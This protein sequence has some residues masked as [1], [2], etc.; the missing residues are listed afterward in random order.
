MIRTFSVT[1]AWSDGH[2]DIIKFIYA[3]GHA[4]EIS[5]DEFKSQMNS[6]IGTSIS[7]WTT[8]QKNLVDDPITDNAYIVSHGGDAILSEVTEE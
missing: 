5:A 4:K 7:D 1:F 3:P 8:A 2:V 6:L